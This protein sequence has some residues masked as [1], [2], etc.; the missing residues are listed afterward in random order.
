[1]LIPKQ[2]VVYKSPWLLLGSAEHSL[3]RHLELLV[4]AHQTLHLLRMRLLLS[5][6]LLQGASLSGER[7]RRLEV[8]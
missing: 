2:F 1:M 6:S 4:G 5:L 8:Q 7:L 3:Q